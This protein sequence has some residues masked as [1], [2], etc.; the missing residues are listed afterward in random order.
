MGNNIKPYVTVGCFD[1]HDLDDL[2]RT[3]AWI[4]ENNVTLPA[5]D[6]TKRI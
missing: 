1:V 2:K 3:E 5:F 6:V 4:T